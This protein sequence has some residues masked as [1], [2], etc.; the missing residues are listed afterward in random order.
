[1]HERAFVLMPLV[2]IAPEAFVPGKGRAA[3]LLAA[4]KDQR[5]EKTGVE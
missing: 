4:C 2:E 3:T 1:M 5:I